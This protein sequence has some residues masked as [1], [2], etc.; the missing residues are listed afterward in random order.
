MME[1]EAVDEGTIAELVVQEG[2]DEVPVSAIIAR[3]SDGEQAAAPA[4]KSLPPSARRAVKDTGVDPTTVSGT[5]RDGW[6]TKVDPVAANSVGHPT[7]QPA[8]TQDINMPT[9]SPTMAKGTIAAARPAEGAHPA[10][11]VSRPVDPSLSPLMGRIVA[12]KGLD[13]TALVG[14]GP[15]G[16]I[17]LADVAPSSQP[18]LPAAMSSAVAPSQAPERRS[19]SARLRQFPTSRITPSNCP[20]CARRSRGG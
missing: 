17:V 6:A 4:N 12:A 19:A 20:A 15:K 18:T 7:P 3:L 8:A 11:P 1:Y 2:T 9:L 5:G 16:R 13:T 14:S 10:P